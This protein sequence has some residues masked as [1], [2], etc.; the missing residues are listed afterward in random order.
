MPANERCRP[1]SRGKSERRPMAPLCR[2]RGRWD[3][4]K[5]IRHRVFPDAMTYPIWCWN[6]AARREKSR[7][8]IRQRA[9]TFINEIGVESVVSVT[10]HAPSLAPF[11]VV[12]WWYQELPDSEP[13]AIRASDENE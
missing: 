1:A 3:S 2:A 10:E 5:S 7:E 13:V 6:A 8:K 11:S 12:V 4:M 9:E